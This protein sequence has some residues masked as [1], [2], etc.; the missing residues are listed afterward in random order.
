MAQVAKDFGLSATTSGKGHQPKMIYPLDGMDAECRVDQMRVDS[1]PFQS[2]GWLSTGN[3]L[4]WPMIR[5]SDTG[6]SP[7]N[8]QRR[9]L[10]GGSQKKR[11]SSSPRK[12]RIRTAGVRSDARAEEQLQH[13]GHGGPARGLP[14]RVL[15]LGGPGAV[16][17][18]D[19]PDTL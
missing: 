5:R 18:G 10:I 9:A 15:R 4:A 19:P 13:R 3:I 12:H 14:V 2:P 7:T 11:P 6:S 16:S 8:S 17:D 1:V